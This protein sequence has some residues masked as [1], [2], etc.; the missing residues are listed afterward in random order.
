[1]SDWFGLHSTVE[2]VAA[3]LDLEMPGPTRH[4]GEQLVSAVRDGSVDRGR[5]AA[6]RGQRRAADGSRRRLRRRRARP[7]DQHVTHLTTCTLARTCSGARA[8][9]CCATKRC[10]AAGSLPLDTVR[11]AARRGDRP[12]RGS[13][14]D[15]GRR[16]R[17]RDTHLD[18]SSARQP[19]RQARCSGVEVVHGAGCNINRR[20][21][22]IERGCTARSRSTT[23]TTRAAL[24][25]P[26]CRRAAHRF[27][28]PCG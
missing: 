11:V 22:E 14:T 9:C 21:P 26:R 4:R 25:D 24:D 18:R 1:M 19:A 28:A 23:S 20:L 15:D 16:Q 17:P 7:G 5:R 6:R 13:R 10:R 27:A 8:W 3:G 12:Q 2:A